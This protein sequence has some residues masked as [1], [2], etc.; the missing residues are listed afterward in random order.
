MSEH[1]KNKDYTDFYIIDILPQF[2]YKDEKK[3]HQFMTSNLPNLK[4]KQS[5]KDLETYFYIN[6]EFIQFVRDWFHL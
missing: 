6:E 5:E 1:L 2:E 3:F 4:T